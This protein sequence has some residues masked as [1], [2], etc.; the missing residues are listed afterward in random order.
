[1]NNVKQKLKT[2]PDKPGCYLFFDNLGY[3]IYVGKSKNL[4]NRV[5]SYF[6]KAAEE[7]ERTKELIPR[8]YD[9][10]VQ[11]ASSELDAILNEY[12]LIKKHKPW[13]NSQLKADKKRPYLIISNH[14]PYPSLSIYEKAP[15]EGVCY[16]DF[17]TNNDDIKYTLDLICKV[18]GLPKCGM[19]SFKKA[20][21]PCIYH[22]IDG[23]LAPC[24]GKADEDRYMFAIDDLKRF[25]NGGKSEFV[26]QL[27]EKMFNASLELNYEKAADY[28][29]LISKLKSLSKKTNRSYHFPDKEDVLV[30]IRPHGEK[31]F[32]AFYIRDGHVLGRKDIGHDLDL[33]L[34]SLSLNVLVDDFMSSISSNVDK[35]FENSWLSTSLTEVIADKK[36]ITVNGNNNK[37]IIKKAIIEFA[38]S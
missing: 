24:S 27:S 20:I 35:Q 38:K 28:K 33:D 31:S 11:V 18:W 23:C 14:T 4:K 8:I 10:E 21:S 17:F 1:M 5:K 34:D 30:L 9:M 6:T 37:E 36:F 2:I 19:K 7:D 29:N 13:Y 3:V 22:S 26:D 15:E 12:S 25:L 16:Y 32:S